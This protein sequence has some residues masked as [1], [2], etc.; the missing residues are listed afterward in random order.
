MHVFSRAEKNRRKPARVLWVDDRELI[1]DSSIINID[2]FRDFLHYQIESL[3]DFIAKKVLL[4]LTLEELGIIIDFHELGK[5]GDFT[6]IGQNPLLVKIE[7]NPDSDK[8]LETLVK[9]RGIISF[10]NGQLVWEIQKAQLWVADIHQAMLRTHNIAHITQGSPGRMSEEEKMQSANTFA[11]RRHLVVAPNMDTLAVWSNYWKGM[12][13]SGRFKEILRVFPK[14]VSD[15]IFILVR[16]T[17][18]GSSLPCEASHP[19]K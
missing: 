10:K 7:G 12:A 14:V 8:F 11:S 17:T 6:T 1:L 18:G 4:G 3:Q 16:V 5:Q 9:K 13:I 15:F 2:I 19:R